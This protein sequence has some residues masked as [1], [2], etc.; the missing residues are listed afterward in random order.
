MNLPPRNPNK[1]INVPCPV[2][3][4]DK[5]TL[6]LPNRAFF[7]MYKHLYYD[8]KDLENH[9]DLAMKYFNRCNI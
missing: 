6:G 4:C 9:M 7:D 2:Q 3:G 1:K 8:H 5:R